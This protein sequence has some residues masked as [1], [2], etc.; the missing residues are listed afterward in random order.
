MAAVTWKEE[1]KTEMDL[2]C[3]WG[4]RRRRGGVEKERFGKRR[5]HKKVDEGGKD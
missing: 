1:K 3:S 2:R 5:R 4:R